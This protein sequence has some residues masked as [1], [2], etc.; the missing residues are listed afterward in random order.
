MHYLWI[1]LGAVVGASARHL[2]F[3]LMESRSI[4]FPC[5]TLVVNVVGCLLIGFI[6]EYFALKSHLPYAV[7]L[8]LVTGVLGSFTT[9]ST[10]ALDGGVVD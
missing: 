9:F 1:G 2:I 4:G 6:A 7:R 5:H 8:F 3:Q 10:F